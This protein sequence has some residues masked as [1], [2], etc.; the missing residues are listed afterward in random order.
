MRFQ[1][2]EPDSDS[3][4]KKPRDAIAADW[5]L[6]AASNAREERTGPSL[7][8]RR[9]ALISMITACAKASCATT[10]RVDP[11]LP[12]GAV[13][14]AARTRAAGT[15]ARCVRDGARLLNGRSIRRGVNY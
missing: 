6:A 9:K 14:Q 7:C 12:A 10:E 2:G 11:A 8:W 13:I 15:S 3:C 5:R 1:N 4:A